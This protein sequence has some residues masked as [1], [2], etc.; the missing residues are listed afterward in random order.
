MYFQPRT[1]LGIL[2]LEENYVKDPMDTDLW[3][4]IYSIKFFYILK[5]KKKSNRKI[6]VYK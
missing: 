5:E 1:Q 6:N 3:F 4:F 2:E